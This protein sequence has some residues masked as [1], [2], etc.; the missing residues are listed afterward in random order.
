M[1]HQFNIL[2][3]IYCQI[4]PIL[5]RVTIDRDFCH[6][7]GRCFLSILSTGFLFLL[8]DR[9]HA[10]RSPCDVFVFCPILTKTEIRRQISG[11]NP[12]YKIKRSVQ[13][14]WRWKQGDI[15]KQAITSRTW[16]ANA[17]NKEFR[18]QLITLFSCSTGLMLLVHLIY[19]NNNSNNNN[20][21]FIIFS[22]ALQPRAGYG[23]LVYEVAWSHTTTRHS[24]KDSSGRV[25]RSSQTHLPNNTQQTSMPPVGFE[26]TIAAGE[27]P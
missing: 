24:R 18:A 26:P 25:I 3:S 6:A 1:Y 11:K 15:T 5:N 13:W 27:R 2:Q 7:R 12:Q 10:W 19:Y 20:C 16:F 23:L 21:Y 17:P 8:R 14:Q 9:R 4:S 22:L